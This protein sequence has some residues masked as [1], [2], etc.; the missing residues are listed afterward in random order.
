MENTHF[1]V[2]VDEWN[3]ENHI[4]ESGGYDYGAEEFSTICLENEYNS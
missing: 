4:H 2:C 3:P 1:M